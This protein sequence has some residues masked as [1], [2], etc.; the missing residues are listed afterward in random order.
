ML[1]VLSPEMRVCI[2]RCQ[3][4]QETCLET[5]NHCLTIDGRH[6]KVSHMLAACAEICDTSARFMLLGSEHY[7]RTCEV[8]AEI[9]EACA[10]DC[11]RVGD[12]QIM[13]RC[14]EAC[15]RCAESCREMAAAH[16]RR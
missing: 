12:D 15:T 8:C 16:A 1:D 7:V 11:E 14:A 10:T 4:C 9:C 5:M 2:D 13:Q 6:A 3:A